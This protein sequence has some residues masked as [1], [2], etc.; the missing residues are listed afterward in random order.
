MA[1]VKIH[2]QLTCTVRKD[3]ETDCYVSHCPILNVFSA[4]NSELEAL[5]AIRSA[6]KMYALALYKQN[7]LDEKLLT[8]G[9]CPVSD[10]KELSNADQF[11]SVEISKEQ[12]DVGRDRVQTIEVDVPLELIVSAHQGALAHA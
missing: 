9:F 7:R 10:K 4:G 8:T 3:E 6:L 11:V 12:V 2:M 1:T 5:E